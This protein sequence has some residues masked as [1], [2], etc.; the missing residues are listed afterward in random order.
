LAEAALPPVPIAE[1]VSLGV[2]EVAPR[3]SE[4]AE[5]PPAAALPPEPTTP[6]VLP[7]VVEAA[8]VPIVDAD[9]PE[10]ALLPPA[11][12][13]VLDPGEAAIADPATSR[14]ATAVIVMRVIIYVSPISDYL[15]CKQR[16]LFF[17][18]IGIIH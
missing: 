3:P 1:E 6:L 11:A 4:E 7:G 14:A 15:C 9:M 10:A 5:V 16:Q 2:D 13:A 18:S 8:P 12:P 17:V